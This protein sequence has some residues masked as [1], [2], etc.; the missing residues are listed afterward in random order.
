MVSPFPWEVEP[1]AEAA[2]L[3]ACKVKLDPE[4]P[5]AEVVSPFAWEVELIQSLFISINM[6]ISEKIF[7]REDGVLVTDVKK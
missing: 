1:V 6:T 4:A 7:W 3:F 5:V 2:E